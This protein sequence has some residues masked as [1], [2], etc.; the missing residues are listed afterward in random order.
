MNSVPDSYCQFKLI[1]QIGPRRSAALL[2]H[3]LH[4]RGRVGQVHRRLRVLLSSRPGHPLHFNVLKCFLFF[5]GGGW[6]SVMLGKYYFLL[7]FVA[8]GLIRRQ[9]VRPSRLRLASTFTT[10]AAISPT[11]MGKGFRSWDVA[12]EI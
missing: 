4:R 8:E 3:R 1:H 11:G 10:T 9:C 7:C 2:R 12:V 5:L 6:L